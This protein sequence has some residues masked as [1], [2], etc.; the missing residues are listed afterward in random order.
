M[1]QFGK[2][3]NSNGS[4]TEDY[5][6]AAYSFNGIDFSARLDDTGS[7]LSFENSLYQCVSMA[8]RA[9]DASG[10]NVYDI[11]DSLFACTHL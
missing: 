2:L 4:S 10:T 5:S 11:F 1:M 6:L 7:K 8:D 9:S 3:N